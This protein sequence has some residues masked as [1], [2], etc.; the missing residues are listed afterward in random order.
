MT[1][2]APA[3]VGLLRGAAEAAAVA[4]VGVVVDWLTTADLGD[5]AVWAA[6]AVLV[7]RTVEGIADQR[8]DPTKQRGR[9]GGSNAPT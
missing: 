5:Y 4:A 7:L 3:L 1:P 8:I 9:L 6:P 2:T